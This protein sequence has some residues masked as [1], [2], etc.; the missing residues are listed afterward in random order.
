M[1]EPTPEEF[2]ELVTELKKIT[3]VRFKTIKKPSCANCEEYIPFA[4]DKACKLEKCKY[5]GA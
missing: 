3:E 2:W 1:K 5:E 4:E